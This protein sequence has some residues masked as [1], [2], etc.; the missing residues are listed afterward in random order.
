MNVIN[1]KEM[2][3]PYEQTVAELKNKLEYIMNEYRLRGMYSPM[4]SI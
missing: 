4:E 1:W 2:L 3:Y